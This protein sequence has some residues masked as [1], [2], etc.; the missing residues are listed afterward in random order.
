[1]APSEVEYQGPT[2]SL[3]IEP[4]GEVGATIDMSE[5]SAGFLIVLQEKWEVG[6]GLRRGAVGLGTAEVPRASS[7]SSDSD[8]ERLGKDKL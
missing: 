1:M 8:Q 4:S 3:E 5:P 6:R 7:C 2:A